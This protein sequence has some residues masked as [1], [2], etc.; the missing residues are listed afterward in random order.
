[1]GCARRAPAPHCVKRLHHP[2]VGDLELTYEVLELPADP[3][4]T[5]CVHSAEPGSPSDDG[6]KALASWA[7]SQELSG[8]VPGGAPTPQ[9][10]KAY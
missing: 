7:A 1:M 3:G 9:T 5:M 10:R 2:V 6:L 4:L 8:T